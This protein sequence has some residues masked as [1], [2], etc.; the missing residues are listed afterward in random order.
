MLFRS[1]KGNDESD[2]GESSDEEDV[3]VYMLGHILN[4]WLYKYNAAVGILISVP[5][6]LPNP[7]LAR[8]R[9]S[10]I[11]YIFTHLNKPH[12]I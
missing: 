10:D 4:E 3:N 12:K 9:T 5:Y 6:P 8:K 1:E 11:R 7:P 2:P